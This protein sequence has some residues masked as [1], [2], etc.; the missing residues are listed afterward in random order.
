MD[1]IGFAQTLMGEKQSEREF[2][3]RE[4]HGY[5][6]QQCLYMAN[7]KLIKMGLSPGKGKAKSKVEPL[8]LYDL[9]ADPTESQNVMAQHPEVV[10]KM[11][12]IMKTQHTP[13]PDFRLPA[14]DR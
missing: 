14:L 12:A 8:Q 10:A 5:G 9:T 1:G 11:E 7:W 2:M 6:G 4:F 13:S 3:Y